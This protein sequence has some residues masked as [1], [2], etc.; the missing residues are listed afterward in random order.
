M[1]G[2]LLSLYLRVNQISVRDFAKQLDI[3]PATVSRITRGDRAD[4]HTM[5]KLMNWLFWSKP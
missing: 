4:Q 3:S 5:L 2:E 1:I